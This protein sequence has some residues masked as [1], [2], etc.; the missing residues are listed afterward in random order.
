M[1]E[2]LFTPHE[3]SRMLPLVR[4]IVADILSTGKQARELAE[5]LGPAAIESAELIKALT[6]LEALISEL[7]ELGCQY[8]DWN[9]K[10]G[11]VDFPAIID[12][13]EVLLCWRSDEP[14]LR[15]YHGVHAGYA[16]RREIPAGLLAEP[17]PS[18]EP[19]R[20]P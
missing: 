12:G 11:L 15:F 7:H 19:G 16:G 18:V 9:F 17:E 6:E 2:R 1:S 13:E 20:T 8:K 3:A 4:R 14:A 5:R 10:A